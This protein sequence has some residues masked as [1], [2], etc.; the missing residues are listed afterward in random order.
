MACVPQIYQAMAVSLAKKIRAG[1]IPD[2]TEI[3]KKYLAPHEPRFADA[4]IRCAH[5]LLKYPDIQKAGWNANYR[6]EYD[7]TAAQESEIKGE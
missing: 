2:D 1:E 4:I 5:R 3:L 6:K 7:E